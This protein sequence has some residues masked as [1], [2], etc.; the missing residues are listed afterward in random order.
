[1]NKSEKQIHKD[2][3]KTN[4]TIEAQPERGRAAQEER[5]KRPWKWWRTEE[6]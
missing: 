5:E 2:E 1:M 3:R 6:K 4:G